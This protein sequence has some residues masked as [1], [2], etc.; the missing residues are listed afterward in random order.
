[1]TMVLTDPAGF[2]VDWDWHRGLTVW[3]LAGRRFE[4]RFDSK[5]LE[6]ELAVRLTGERQAR[7]VA[8]R[9]WRTEGRAE[10]LSG[11]VKQPGS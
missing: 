2:A 8:R 11:T 5:V 10:A 3:V 6:H 9:W 4:S 7:A 1:M